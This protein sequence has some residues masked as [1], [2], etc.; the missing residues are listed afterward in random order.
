ML[1]HQIQY[2]RCRA[3][4]TTTEDYKFRQT[5]REHEDTIEKLRESKYIAAERDA[6][7]CCKSHA[8]ETKNPFVMEKYLEILK[9]SLYTQIFGKNEKSLP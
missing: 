2:N 3:L 5:E 9:Y 1:K 6:I 7:I 4:D 8:E